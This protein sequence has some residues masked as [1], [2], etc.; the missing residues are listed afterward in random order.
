MVAQTEK[1]LKMKSGTVF[2]LRHCRK[3]I[4]HDSE[5]TCLQQRESGD[6]FDLTER[7]SVHYYRNEDVKEDEYDLTLIRRAN[8]I[9]EGETS[10]DSDRH[11]GCEQNP[12]DMNR[13][14]TSVL[15][16]FMGKNSS[17]TGQ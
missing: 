1:V 3:W 16:K 8:P 10:E 15:F 12:L 6:D 2:R 14:I 4:D 5:Q 17:S 13:W 9:S 7:V 11:H